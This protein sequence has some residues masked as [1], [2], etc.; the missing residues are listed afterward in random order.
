MHGLM[1]TPKGN[2]FTPDQHI[3][4]PLGDGETFTNDASPEEGIVNVQKE[5]FLIVQ[6]KFTGV[7][8]DCLDNT[9]FTFEGEVNEV[10]GTHVVL[11]VPQNADNAVVKNYLIDVRG[12]SRIRIATIKNNEA[13]ADGDISDINVGWEIKYEE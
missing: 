3:T 2:F 10:W 5:D 6:P 4:P 9:I 1:S 11:N 7:T 12:L 13:T 8:A